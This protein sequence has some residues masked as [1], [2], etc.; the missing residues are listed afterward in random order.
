MNSLQDV[1][2]T[3]IARQIPSSHSIYLFY[4]ETSSISLMTEV[5]KREN[6]SGSS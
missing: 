3:L 2:A 5:E 1:F 6:N 4:Q